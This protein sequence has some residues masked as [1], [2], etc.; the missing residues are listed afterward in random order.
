MTKG[1]LMELVYTKEELANIDT[2]TPLSTWKDHE[3][4]NH[5]MNYNNS[6]FGVLENI[7]DIAEQRKIKL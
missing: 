1:Q 3:P 5:V 4:F 7:Y 6:N 2:A